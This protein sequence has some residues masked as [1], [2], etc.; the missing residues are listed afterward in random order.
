MEIKNCTTVHRLWGTLD[1]AELITA[2]QYDTD[3]ED[4]CKKCISR[5]PPETSLVWVSHYS[6]KMNI[7]RH[8]S[9]ALA[10]TEA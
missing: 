8:P 9:S 3:A 2:F 6:G 5:H 4:F 10:T 7:V 1:D